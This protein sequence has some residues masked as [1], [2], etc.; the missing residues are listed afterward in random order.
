MT[1]PDRRLASRTAPCALC[2]A[3]ISTW[4]PP[5]TPAPDWLDEAGHWLAWAAVALVSV[6][7]LIALGNAGRA[8]VGWVTG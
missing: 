7:W 1:A 3:D 4:D 8:V 6:L 2:H 5:P